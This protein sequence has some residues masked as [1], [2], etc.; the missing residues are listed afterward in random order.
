ML[1]ALFC[2]IPV[3]KRFCS[4][5]HGIQRFRPSGPGW[6]RPL[7]ILVISGIYITTL[8]KTPLKM[9]WLLYKTTRK[10]IWKSTSFYLFN[11]HDKKQNI[12]KEFCTWKEICALRGQKNH[13]S[14][15]WGV[16]LIVDMG[17]MEC[18]GIL[19]SLYYYKHYCI[20]Y[21]LQHQMCERRQPF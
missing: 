13:K 11:V 4:S 19:T 14:C 1:L 7:V 8:E 12:L 2:E 16:R 5:A 3:H 6:N 15:I 21:E 10:K 20:N 18:L 9:T 17:S